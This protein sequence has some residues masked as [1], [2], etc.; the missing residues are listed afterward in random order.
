MHSLNYGA[1]SI[2]EERG[3]KG[4]RGGGRERERD[5][6]KNALLNLFTKHGYIFSFS[7]L[8]LCVCVCVNS[9]ESKGERV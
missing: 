5:P 6:L 4:E 9:Q 1:V 2:V 3:K 7:Y 8:Y